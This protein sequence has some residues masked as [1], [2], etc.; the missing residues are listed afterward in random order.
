MHLSKSGSVGN[1]DA[2]KRNSAETFPENP[3]FKHALES[4]FLMKTTCKTHNI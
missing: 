4:R 2:L 3:D 1:K